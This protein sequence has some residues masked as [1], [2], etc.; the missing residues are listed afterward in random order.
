MQKW[1]RWYY[2]RNEKQEQDRM[3]E[4]T[5]QYKNAEKNVRCSLA[6]MFWL[7]ITEHDRDFR[8]TFDFKC[9]CYINLTND[10]MWTYEQWNLSESASSISTSLFSLLFLSFS[11]RHGLMKAHTHTNKYTDKF[12]AHI[13]IHTCIHNT[14]ISTHSISNKISI[15]K[16][17]C[18]KSN[19]IKWTKK[20]KK[21]WTAYTRQSDLRWNNFA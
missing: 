17:Q 21:K 5:P 16:H 15:Y 10:G 13:H 4:W 19:K 7:F 20:E 2:G 1:A 8:Q 9:I 6:A 12:T 11:F 14:Y 3:N 18:R